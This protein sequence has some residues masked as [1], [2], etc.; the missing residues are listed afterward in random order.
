MSYEEE[1]LARY[2]TP[3]LKKHSLEPES[4]PDVSND[5][6]EITITHEQFTLTNNTGIPITV[7][8]TRGD[9]L[10]SPGATYATP[11]AKCVTSGSERGGKDQ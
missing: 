5:D 2:S 3:G 4:P 9:I 7:H 10:V 1:I 8:T 11:T 6:N